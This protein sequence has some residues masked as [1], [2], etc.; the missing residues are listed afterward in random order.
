[1]EDIRHIIP[2]FVPIIAII[3]GIAIGMLGL[4]LDYRK[5]SRMFELHHQER[6]LAI[7]RGME[8][9]PLPPEFF[10][11]PR[12]DGGSGSGASSLRWGLIWLLLGA[13]L[14]VAMGL[15]DGIAQAS[16]ALLPA[17]VGLA[18]IIFYFLT[19]PDARTAGA[20]PSAQSGG[21]SQRP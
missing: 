1:M 7:E 6:L 9:P 16:W 3:L 13:A 21:G 18:Q 14:G 10:F 20:K 17:A 4:I 8:V 11:N 2:F 15:N 19:A 12:R 5:K